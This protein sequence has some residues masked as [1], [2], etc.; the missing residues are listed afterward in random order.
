ML[1]A[2]NRFLVMLLVTT[3]AAWIVVYGAVTNPFVFTMALGFSLPIT[4]IAWLFVLGRRPADDMLIISACL[5][6]I[7]VVGLLA[8]G[9]YYQD[10]RATMGVGSATIAGLT[11]PPGWTMGLALLCLFWISRRKQPETVEDEAENEN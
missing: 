11:G 7:F 9:G 5:W 10:A 3:L 1:V 4:L 8:H 2:I 6:C